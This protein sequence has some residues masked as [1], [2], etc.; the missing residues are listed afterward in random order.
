[1]AS[2]QH[3]GRR[4]L[5]CAVSVSAIALALAPLAQAEKHERKPKGLGP[6]VTATAIGPVATTLAT[7]SEATATCPKRKQAVS[8]GFSAPFGA[9]GA[10]VVNESYRISKRA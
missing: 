2:G 9:S 3:A 5:C 7:T 1:M 6:V 4:P 8:G 10:L